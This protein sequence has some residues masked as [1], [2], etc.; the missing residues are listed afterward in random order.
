MLNIDALF[1]GRHF[2]REIIV[3]CV[4]WYLRYKLSFRDLVEM[5]AERG[6]SLGLWCKRCRPSN[7][8]PGSRHWS[9]AKHGIPNLRRG[10]VFDA[11]STE[12]ELTLPDPM[13]EFDAG[14]R[15]CGLA[16]MLEAEH[17]TEP[18]LDGSVILFDQIVIWHV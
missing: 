17:R 8:R 18:K 2:D 16:E 13:H 1:K 4:R 10:F 12:F 11:K 9:R 15:R 7:Q 3:L 5:M 14:D 6:L